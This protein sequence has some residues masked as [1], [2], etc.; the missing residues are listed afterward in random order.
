MKPPRIVITATDTDVGKTM[1]AAALCAA[2]G[3]AYWKPVQSGLEEI[4]SET[5]GRL[6]GANI[7][8]EAYRLTRPLSPHRSAELDGV[9]IDP[10]RLAPPDVEGPLVI[11]GAGG[12]LV[13]LSR[14]ILFAE[15]FARWQIPVV[16]CARTTLGTINHSL[17]SIDA[18]RARAVPIRGIAFIGDA[19]ADNERTICDFGAVKRLGR[20]PMLNAPDR[21]SLRDAFLQN[22]H[23][24]DFG[25]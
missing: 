15:M 1:F 19:N 9:T 2:S 21:I 7:L 11:E 20:L 25:L 10:A 6:S 8:P 3:A 4:D 16:L 24:E 14:D 5:V 13:P 22:F 18:L 12:V 17:L 23:L